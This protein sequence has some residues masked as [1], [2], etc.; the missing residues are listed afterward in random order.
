MLVLKPQKYCRMQNT[1]HS[2]CKQKCKAHKSQ[3]IRFNTRSKCLYF[4]MATLI[5][6]PV[7]YWWNAILLAVNGAVSFSLV[8]TTIIYIHHHDVHSINRWRKLCTFEN[9][10]LTFD[11]TPSVNANSWTRG[12]YAWCHCLRFGGDGRWWLM[13]RP[14]N[15]ADLRSSKGCSSNKANLD[16]GGVFTRAYCPSVEH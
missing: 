7:D 12:R 13:C 11:K 16:H 15:V 6:V 2:K 14:V 3:K 1:K 10:W 8:H 5:F 4:N 9:I